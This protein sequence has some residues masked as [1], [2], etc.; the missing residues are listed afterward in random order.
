[1]KT[2]KLKRLYLAKYKNAERTK[3][4]RKVICSIKKPRYD[5]SIE[6]EG[7]LYQNSAF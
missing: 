6:K 1:M 5:N 2:I 3:K 7:S 4:C